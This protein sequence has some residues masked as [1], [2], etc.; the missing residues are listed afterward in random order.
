MNIP[1]YDTSRF[2][3]G[4]G[5]LY[6]GVPG[7]TPVLDIGAIKGGAEFTVERKKLEV[8]QGSPKTLV[9]Q[10]VIEETL[11]IKCTGLE[12]NL[13]NLAY[14]MGAG[15]TMLGGFS[16]TLEFGGDMTISERA[17]KFVHIMPDGSTIE[18]DVWKV[19]SSGKIPINFNDADMHEFPY[20]FNALV[21]TSNFANQ[22]PGTTSKLFK[23]IRVKK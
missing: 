2:S 4:P 19:Q 14:C 8:K 18:I 22:V 13:N 6:M 11:S 20:E 21:G 16:E 3:F 5:I 10:Y 7:E 12:W 17:L 9:K 23:I 1:S 15:Q